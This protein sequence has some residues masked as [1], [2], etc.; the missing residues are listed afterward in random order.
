MTQQG[1]KSLKFKKKTLFG[2]LLDMWIIAVDPQFKNLNKKVWC[3]HDWWNHLKFYSWVK[4]CFSCSTKTSNNWTKLI[5]F[6]SHSYLHLKLTW[7]KTELQ[8]RSKKDCCRPYLL[9]NL[10]ETTGPSCMGSPAKTICPDSLL[11][12]L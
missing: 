2:L 12:S 11:T 9:A 4:H 10:L 6:L 5:I 3:G 8:S 7:Y 1:M